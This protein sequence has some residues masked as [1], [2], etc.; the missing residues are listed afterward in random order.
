MKIDSD[1]TNPIIGL[2]SH[3]INCHFSIG[4]SNKWVNISIFIIHCHGN[5][6]AKIR[7]CSQNRNHEYIDDIAL[8]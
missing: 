4:V 5:Y 8:I 1:A 2:Y 3:E 7:K 6:Y